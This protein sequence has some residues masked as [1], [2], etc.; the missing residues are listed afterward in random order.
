VPQFLRVSR[1]AALLVIAAFQ[2]APTA[3]GDESPLSATVSSS[4]ATADDHIRQF[5]FDGDPT[6]AFISADNPHANDSFT[7]EFD[8]PVAVRSI[9]SSA[10]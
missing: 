2:I 3:N 8:A 1:V 4:L 10:R 5:A 9:I 6:T 7:L